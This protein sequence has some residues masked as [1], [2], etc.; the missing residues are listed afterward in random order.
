MPDHKR[1]KG[2]LGDAEHDN[3]QNADGE[4]CHHIG[5]DDRDLVDRGNRGIHFSF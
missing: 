2:V 3:K 4:T 1:N 5:V